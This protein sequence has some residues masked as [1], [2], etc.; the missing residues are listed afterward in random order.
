M[1]GVGI[2]EFG[3]ILDGVV[4]VRGG[5]LK[6]LRPATYSFDMSGGL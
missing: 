3:R 4:P 6:I 5:G 1:G 2:A